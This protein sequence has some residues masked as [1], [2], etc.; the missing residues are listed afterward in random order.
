MLVQCFERLETIPILREQLV[1]M[2]KLGWSDGSRDVRNPLGGLAQVTK[3]RVQAQVEEAARRA[4]ETAR[5][6]KIEEAARKAA[7]LARLKAF[8][9]RYPCHK[10]DEE[11]WQH[12]SFSLNGRSATWACRYCEKKIIVKAAE[13]VNATNRRAPIPNHVQIAVGRLLSRVE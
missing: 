3:D 1:V 13:A 5:K 9:P 7:E 2:R 12:I 8:L 11:Q 6:T 10:C 4:A